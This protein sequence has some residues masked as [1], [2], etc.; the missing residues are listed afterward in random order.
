MTKTLASPARWAGYRSY[1]KGVKLKDNPFKPGTEDHKQ[2][3]LGWHEAKAL[4]GG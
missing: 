1:E 2:W 4:Y 3:D